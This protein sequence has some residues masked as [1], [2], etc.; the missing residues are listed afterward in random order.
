MDKIVKIFSDS[1]TEGITFSFDK[2]LTMNYRSSRLSIEFIEYARF[3]NKY[4][5]H[6]KV[7]LDV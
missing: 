3:Q 1:A 5:G 7:S 6:I 2:F 4:F